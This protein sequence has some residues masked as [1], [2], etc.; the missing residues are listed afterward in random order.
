MN[1]GCLSFCSGRDGN[2]ELRASLRVH[3]S[4]VETAADSGHLDFF[5]AHHFC[6]LL[7]SLR[8]PAE[9]G[10]LVTVSVNVLRNFASKIVSTDTS[11][12]MV[13]CLH[14]FDGLLS[15]LLHSKGLKDFED[16]VYLSLLVQL[17]DKVFKDVFC[18]NS[19]WFKLKRFNCDSL[20][21]DCFSGWKEYL[22]EELREHLLSYAGGW[23]MLEKQLRRR[24]FTDQPN[25]SPRGDSAFIYDFC[26]VALRT[27]IYSSCTS[28][29]EISRIHIAYFR[30]LVSK[31][32][33][34]RHVIFLVNAHNASAAAGNNNVNE[35][36][37]TVLNQTPNGYR[38]ESRDSAASSCV[39]VEDYSSAL[40][41]NSYQDLLSSHLS[42]FFAAF[43]TGLLLQIT[44]DVF[45]ALVDPP[46][47]FL[48]L[49]IAMHPTEASAEG[50]AAVRKY[51]CGH[52]LV[53]LRSLVH[54]RGNRSVAEDACM[55][56]LMKAEMSLSSS[57]PRR[58]NP[59]V[60]DYRVVS[61]LIR[62]AVSLTVSDRTA[63]VGRRSNTL[64]KLTFWK[65]NSKAKCPDTLVAWLQYLADTD[66]V[67]VMTSSSEGR[68]ELRSI[69][70]EIS[71]ASVNVDSATGWESD[72]S[73]KINCCPR[74]H[75]SDFRLLFT[76]ANGLGI[77]PV[78]VGSVTL[79]ESGIVFMPSKNTPSHH[80]VSD[81]CSRATSPLNDV[82][83]P[84]RPH[85]Q[86]FETR[87]LHLETAIT[88][89]RDEI[90]NLAQEVARLKETSML[91]NDHEMLKSPEQKA[92]A[93]FKRIAYGVAS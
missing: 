30:Y 67:T 74:I 80:A 88:S 20:L 81:C 61:A 45:N 48:R 60:S 8:D 28:T 46:T 54:N 5:S 21:N 92:E 93:L 33:F 77:T 78:P 14:G 53:S 83:S 1:G 52:L 66:L 49:M 7:G 18:D 84:V 22:D 27:P 2:R 13:R 47:E 36:N 82:S 50:H 75:R 69:Y 26:P 3:C 91:S 40:P 55:S 39:S 32:A 43:G 51:L 37:L 86:I 64:D 19:A 65:N 11:S 23:S 4:R 90:L 42:C 62:A 31:R 73:E 57:S 71:A 44:N 59:I 15:C 72:L 25:S 56:F 38:R 79:S 24:E 70:R 85:D 16:A 76:T 9:L 87:F 35:S 58:K 17:G 34:A 63:S 41:L 6:S 12:E 68:K 89:L 10:S 29:C